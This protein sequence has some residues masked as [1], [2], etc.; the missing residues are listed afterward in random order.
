MVREKANF[1]KPG[2]QPRQYK[3]LS[4]DEKDDGLFKD[5]LRK[6]FPETF[7]WDILKM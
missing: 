5:E 7:V 4:I 2:E 3:D 6:Y 1:P